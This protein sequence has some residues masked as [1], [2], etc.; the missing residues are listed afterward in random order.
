LF[1][2]GARALDGAREALRAFGTVAARLAMLARRML[3]SSLSC[4][5]SGLRARPLVDYFHAWLRS[6]AK[7]RALCLQCAPKPK[8]VCVGSMRAATKPRSLKQRRFDAGRKESPRIICL[9]DVRLSGYW[10]QFSQ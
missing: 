6:I 4:R 1:Y 5:R 7:K 8:A 10:L 9:N 3:S 2:I